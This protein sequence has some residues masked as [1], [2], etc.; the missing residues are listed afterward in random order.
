LF[1]LSP[2]RQAMANK[3]AELSVGYP[4]SPL[5]VPGPHGLAPAA[6]QRAPFT[7]TTHPVGSGPVPRFALFAPSAPAGAELLARYP[8]LLEPKIRAPYA[9]H[10]IWLVR[11]DGYV[12]TVA[13]GDH[14]SAIDD[15]LQRVVV[16]ATGD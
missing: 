10:G 11:P 9:E 1:G 3:L 14:W 8:Q 15:Y 5:T 12:A 6:G 7:D 13:R 4:D 16:G 2:V